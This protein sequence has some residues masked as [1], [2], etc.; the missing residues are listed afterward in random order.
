[1]ILYVNGD[2]HTAAAEAVNP[3]AFAE[4]DSNLYYL[5]RLPHP[6]NL[7]VSW[8]KLLSLALGAGFKCDAE[9]AGSNARI[10]RT[11]RAWLEERRNS[12]ENK[13]VIIQWSTWERE[14]W[15]HEGTWYQVNASGQDSVPTELIQKYKSYVAHVDW[16]EKT[17]AAHDDIWQFHQELVDQN[18]PHVFFN[19]N[20]DFSSIPNQLDWGNNYIEPYNPAGTYH[21]QLQAAGIQTVM[22]G[23]YHYGRNGHAWWFKH[24]LK[25]LMDN[26]FV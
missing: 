4:D 21:A 25:Y 11:T 7:Q 16:R 5:G 19:G 24:I 2:S 9:S 17:Q 18:I 6:E 14:E 20:T 13:L 12:L 26:K 1:M 23:S 10:L 8:G 15:L 22:P 3:H